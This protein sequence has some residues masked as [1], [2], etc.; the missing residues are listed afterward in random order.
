MSQGWK[1]YLNLL[2]CEENHL[3]NMDEYHK[4][5]K[6][7]RDTQDLL[8]RLDTE[9]N[10]KYNPDFKD[11]YQLEGLLTDLND[12]SRVMDSFEERVKALQNRSL[13]VL[14]LKYRRTAPQKL[15]PI[16]A[17]CDFDTDAGQIH[18]GERYTL[19]RN[20]GQK[21]DVKDSSGRTMAAPA[22]CFIIPP[23]DP[24]SVAIT[25]N[26]V[27][28]QEANKQKLASSKTALQ[29]RLADLKKDSTS[30]QD[31]TV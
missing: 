28:Q 24:D 9:I 22:V 29:S 16:E 15:L 4:F 6:E 14:P 1:E 17:L 7:A 23:T 31:N 11:Q 25:D 5:Q 27:S 18:R 8:K 21:W 12:Q 20:N 26:L 3:Q 19:L 2:I 30:G 13:Q 10:Q